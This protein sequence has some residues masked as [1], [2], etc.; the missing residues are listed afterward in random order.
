MI[1][2]A[3]SGLHSNGYSLVRHVLRPAGLDADARASPELGRTLGE[4]LLEPTRIYSLD[5]L[6][7]ARAA[8][9]TPSRTSPAAGSPPTWPGSLPPGLDAV[10]DRSTWTPA[11]GVRAARRGRRRG[12]AGHGA[13]VQHGRRHGARRARE[14]STPRSRSWGSAGA[15]VGARRGRARHRRGAPIDEVPRRPRPARTKTEP[16]PACRPQPGRVRRCRRST[17]AVTHL[18]ETEAARGPRHRHRRRRNRR[19]DRPAHR[20]SSFEHERLVVVVGAWLTPSSSRRRSRSVPPL[21]YFSW[22]ATFTCLALA[23]PRPIGSTPSCGVAPDPGVANGTT[24]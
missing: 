11:A 18:V 14:R 7:L 13:D 10:L 24:H 16:G 21:L 22:R 12:R 8:R 4:E 19:T 6:A 23:R 17:K 15:G 2:L 5:C 9:C 1:A 3:S 20:S